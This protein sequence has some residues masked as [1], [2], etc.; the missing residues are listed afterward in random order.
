MIGTNMKKLIYVMLLV[1][2]AMAFLSCSDSV[3]YAELKR[4]EKKYIK[5]WLDSAGVKVISE[6]Q[7]YA[8]DTMTDVSKNEYVLFDDTGI[9]MQ[10]ENKGTGI[11]VNDGE[12]R[13][14]LCR[15]VEREVSS[16]DTLTTN[17]F[18]A[19]IVDVMMVS[20]NSGTYSGYFTSG[21]LYANYSSAAVPYGWLAPMSYIF[22][23]RELDNI[24]KV[25][26]ILP[27]DQGTSDASQS[28]IPCFY[29]ITYQLGR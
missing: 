23:N 12:T 26:L 20:N 4:N 28:V 6:S 9:Y 11:R 18:S 1:F 17:L 22:L 8:Q 21:Y 27:H 19:S 10:I 15:Y 5:H 24:A 3:S 29:E 2:P 16:G 13:K 25:N 7:F 14:V